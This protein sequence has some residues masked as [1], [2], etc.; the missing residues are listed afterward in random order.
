MVVQHHDVHVQN[1]PLPNELGRIPMF[2]YSMCD[3][4]VIDEIMMFLCAKYMQIP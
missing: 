1:I 3:H 4:D 2:M